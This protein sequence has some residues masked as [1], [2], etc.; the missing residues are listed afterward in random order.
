VYKTYNDTDYKAQGTCCY[1]EDGRQK[2][3]NPQQTTTTPMM[4]GMGGLH[5]RAHPPPAVI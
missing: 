2:I 3:A 1:G 5:D 4:T